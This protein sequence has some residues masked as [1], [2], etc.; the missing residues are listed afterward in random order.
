MIELSREQKAYALENM[1]VVT[2]IGSSIGLQYLR[3]KRGNGREPLLVRL[4]DQAP[5]EAMP[6]PIAAINGLLGHK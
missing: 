5:G 1:L 6:W 3:H 2:M 4:I